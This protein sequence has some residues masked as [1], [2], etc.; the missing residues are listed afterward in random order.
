MVRAAD[1]ARVFAGYGGA[2][3]QRLRSMDPWRFDLLLAVLIGIEMQIEL[4]L[5]DAPIK[6]PG[7]A[8][9]LFAT[10][11]L[12]I[13]LR[14]RVPL[15]GFTLALCSFIAALKYES[16]FEDLL[17]GP[18]FAIFFV[19]YSVGA[20]AEGRRVFVAAGLGFALVAATFGPLASD[21][22][23]VLFGLLVII[24]FPLA[25]GRVISHRTKLN[26]ALRE[27]TARLE[28]ERAERAGT[29]AEDER[30]RIA[31]ELHDVVAHALSAMVIQAG[32]ARRMAASDPDRAREAFAAVE[33]TGRDALT[34]M[35]RLLGVLRKDDEDL[36][37]AP[38]PSLTHLATLIRRASAAGL[39]VELT[40][41]GEPF[42]LPAGIDLIAYRVVQEALSAALESNSA[43]QADV[44][45]RYTPGV[46]EVEVA[47]DG[48]GTRELLGIRERVTLYGGDLLAGRRREGGHVV[49]ARLPLEAAA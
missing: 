41:E 2:V 26:E 4:L 9:A 48:G 32:G 30:A 37:L 22:G 19:V 1:D 45:V 36:A 40:V 33:T 20:H 5:V 38:Q 27:K 8:H 17:E 47:D 25:A 44:Q 14:R 42:S 35:R 16:R 12:G 10:Y 43:G 49:H 23:D 28:A 18:F 34:E 29:A 13:A 31:G 11:A 46:V 6:A 15:V 3:L 24:A 7:P 39:P 21:V